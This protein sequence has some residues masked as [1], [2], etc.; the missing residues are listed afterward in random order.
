MNDKNHVAEYYQKR[1]N[2]NLYYYISGMK[3]TEWKHVRTGEIVK[4]AQL[5]EDVHFTNPTDIILEKFT[6]LIE[7]PN[8]CVDCASEQEF[9]DNY[10]RIIKIP[11]IPWYKRFL[12][13]KF[14][15][16]IME[17]T[18]CAFSSIFKK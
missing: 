15:T 8:G 7:Y 11:N 10:I 5:K 14:I 18:K 6:F 3:L 1:L 4:A 9:Y 2:Q 12:F 16:S 13:A 17:R